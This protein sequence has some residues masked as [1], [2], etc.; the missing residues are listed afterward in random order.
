M[1]RQS[2][3]RLNVLSYLLILTRW[4]RFL[5]LN[6]ILWIAAAVIVSMLL[7]KSYTA[8]VVMMPPKSSSNGLSKLAKNLPMAKLA[9]NVGSLMSMGGS[10]NL[11]N[12]Y[13]A[14]L[15]SR[16]LQMDVIH[17]YELI[18]VYKFDR[19]RRYYIEDVIKAFNKHVGVEVTDEGTFV[20]SVEDRDPVRAA[21]MANFMAD[22]LDEIYKRLAVE[23]EHNQRMFLEDRLKLSKADLD[24][25]ETRY[26]QYLIDNRMLD[27]DEQAKAT[28]EAGS[29][30]EARYMAAELKLDLSRKIFANGN[31]KIH[32]QEMELSELKRQRNQMLKE[33]KS[34]LLIP[35]R[36][37]PEI[38]QQLIRLKRDL[39]VQEAIFEFIMQ[40]YET[41]KFEEAKNTPV[42]QILDKAEPPQKKTFPKRVIIVLMA[43]A[44]SVVLGIGYATFVEY[45]R[46]FSVERPDD[47]RLLSEIKGNLWSKA[48]VRG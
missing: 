24:S 43:A 31:P 5:I 28:I 12:I 32:E 34:D 25:A 30:I 42:V 36:M 29:N 2:E 11:E 45:F 22:R 9:G 15:A 47:F 16:S 27:I 13:L 14:I 20:I 19:K 38:G 7:P 35:Y 4:K 6:S 18:H 17:K 26:T 39:K 37:A 3:I 33:R 41:S 8:Q 10:E 40:Q 23:T 48:S 44:G 46:K 21:D 1:A